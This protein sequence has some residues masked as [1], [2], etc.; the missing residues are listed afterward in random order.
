M[1]KR[2]GRFCELLC[3]WVPVCRAICPNEA[4]IG[5]KCT[6]RAYPKGLSK[7]KV[8]LAAIVAAF[9]ND[10]DIGGDSDGYDL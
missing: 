10:S 8:D 3:D 6:A 4:S 1:A 2:K 7:T 5:T 9:R